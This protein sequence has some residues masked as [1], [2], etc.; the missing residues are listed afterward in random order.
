MVMMQIM[1]TP[2]LSTARQMLHHWLQ[3]GRAKVLLEKNHKIATFLGLDSPPEQVDSEKFY[4]KELKLKRAKF[5]KAVIPEKSLLDDNLDQLCQCLRLDSI[6]QEIL[7]YLC[8]EALVPEVRLLASFL[9]HSTSREAS[10]QIAE[11]LQLPTDQVFKRLNQNSKLIQA[12]L[13]DRD[14][15]RPHRQSGGFKFKI[16]EDDLVYHLVEEPFNFKRVTASLGN[17]GPSTHLKL[18]DFIHIK[19]TLDLL[20]PYLKKSLLGKEPGVNILIHGSPG[21]GKTELGRLLGSLLECGTFEP[22]FFDSDG[23]PIC[24]G[25]RLSKLRCALSFLKDEQSLIVF[26]E[27][28]DLF[29]PRHK[30]FGG[31]INKKLWINRLLE[32]NE[33]PVIWLSN[34]IG[35][36]DPAVLRRFDFVFEVTI[37]GRKQRHAIIK[38]AVGKLVSDPLIHQLADHEHLSPAVVTRASRVLQTISPDLSPSSH[39][40]A[41]RHLVTQSLIAQGKQAISS[42]PADQLLTYDVTHTNAS[43]NLEKLVEGLRNS[44]QA[45]ICLKGPPGTGKTAFGKWLAESLDLALHSR[46]V[47]DLVSM[48]VGE[49]EKSIAQAFHRATD[50]GAILM[51]D[52]VDSLLA[53]RKGASRNWEITQV[54]E[55]LTQM[56]SFQGILIAT[57]NR[58]TALDSASQRRFDLTISLNYLS[59]GQVTLI[60]Q[61]TCEI[62]RLSGCVDNRS[63]RGIANATPGDFAALSRQHRFQPFCNSANLADALVQQ[64]AEKKECKS[65][66]AIGFQS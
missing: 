21:T 50:E 36:M 12:G 25:R 39:N 51:L 17:Q 54:N 55:M 30:P 34:S 37:P 60:F 1:T 14:Y 15:P 3:P 10:T 22:S 31:T 4:D 62:L 65:R 45:R 52:E 47:S 66:P 35:N 53:D 8:I 42:V 23:D 32:E 2:L 29:N 18:D 13:V 48:F 64:C 9:E 61:K 40:E 28:E 59:G 19:S 43:V 33:L 46:R 24:T 44:K 20:V 49:T 11:C 38:N 27:A 5:L 41:F 56:E 26:D 58:V 7:R 6:E 57:T 63:L 16:V